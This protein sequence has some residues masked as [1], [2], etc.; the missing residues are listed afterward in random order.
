MNETDLNECTD[1]D[2]NKNN[3][4]TGNREVNFNGQSG[5]AL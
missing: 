3:R 1:R 2:I 5:K 4:K